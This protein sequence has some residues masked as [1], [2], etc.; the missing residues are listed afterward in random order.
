MSK[1]ILLGVTG[2]IAAYKI[3]DVASRLKKQG[4][5]LNTIMT[6]NACEFVNPLS[7]ETITSN[8]VVTD[9]FERSHKWEVEHIELAKKADIFLVA[10]ATAN[11][12]GKVANGI[13]DDMLSTT[14]MACK[15]TVIFAPAMNTAMYENSI[16][17]D[18]IE[19]L[20]SKG[21]LFIEPDSGMLACGDIG[22]GKL[23]SPD[24][25][26]S[27]VLSQSEE[28]TELS[29]LNF[30]VTAGRTIEAI[31]PMR[32]V[33]NHSTGTMGYAIAKVA[34]QKGA[35]VTL[36]S[37]P[38]N[39]D[40]P[41]GV[42]RINIKSAQEMYDEV[43]KIY[44][45][46]DVVIKTAAVADY[47]P[48]NTSEQKI[49]KSGDNLVLEFI[50]NPDILKSLGEIKTHQILVG[51]A[52]ESENVIENAKAKLVKKNLDFIVANDISQEG[53]GFGGN[54]NIATI[55]SKDGDMTACPLMLKENLATEI[56][57]KIKNFVKGTA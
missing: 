57:E 5:E 15:K 16:V 25:I 13:A 6:K 38:T 18:N 8:Y 55:I 28:T 27:F 23:P 39:L 43:H 31:D 52:A 9:T 49:K 22:R 26:V 14:I 46:Q 4:Y 7:F 19:Y 54:T 37:G 36:I 33:S 51:F 17:Q 2:G 20:K 45:A 3:L 42:T 53:A 10:P 50:P 32:Y 30:L 29:G 11:I 24:N 48:K 47:R 44:A 40:T 34:A 35:N 41:S 1:H 56:I 21:Y 12:I